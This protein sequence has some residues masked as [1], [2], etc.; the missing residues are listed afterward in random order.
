VRQLTEKKLA[1]ITKY[2]NDILD[3]RV[4]LEQER[5]LYVADLFVKGK[6]FDIHSSSQHKEMTAAIQDAVDKL[7]M[8]AR[9]AKTRLKK[10]KGR[11][12]A[13]ESAAE[14]AWSVDVLESESLG[15]GE[16][17]IV[18]R[19]SIPIKPMTVEE[20]AMQLEDG[21]LDFLVFRNASTDRV[22]VLYRRP[23]NNL[24]LITPEL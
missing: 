22:N 11:S 3:V 9:R 8:Q 24:G 20:A 7:E 2:F 12:S 14:S 10:H 15:R 6:D 4:E 5:H 19:S 17:R 1:K 16:P 23:D 18:E 13:A 21:T